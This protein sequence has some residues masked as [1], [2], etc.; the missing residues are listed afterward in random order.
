MVDLIDLE[1]GEDMRQFLEAQKKAKEMLDKFP[2]MIPSEN[3]GSLMIFGTG[4]SE[5]TNTE[6]FHK[7]L[8][9]RL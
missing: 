9:K 3:Q 5:K 2:L 6:N 8:N 1:I 4:Q 7:L